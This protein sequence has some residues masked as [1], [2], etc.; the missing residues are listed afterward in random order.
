M[1]QSKLKGI[2]LGTR[3]IALSVMIVVAVMTIGSLIFLQWEKRSRFD[4]LKNTA[5]TVSF[6]MCNL[7]VDPFIYN[8]IMK[9]DGIAANAIKEK[10]VVFAFFVDADGKPLTSVQSGINVNDPLIKSSV[11]EGDDP[12]KVLSSLK[13]NRGVVSMTSPVTDGEK[14]LGN[15]VIG[16]S[17]ADA[18]AAFY[19]AL[20]YMLLM[21]AGIIL[22]LSA[23]MFVMF[24]ET[25][26]KPIR[27]ILDLTDAVAGGDLT[28]T[29][30][31]TSSDEMGHLAAAINKM[32]EGFRDSLRQTVNSAYAVSVAAEKVS[33]NSNVIA[34]S[35]Q[36]ESSAAEQTAASIGKIAYSI[37]QVAKNAGTLAANVDESSSTINEM[38]AS[39]EQVGKS[40]DMMAS[41]VEKASSAVEQMLFSVDQTARNSGAMTEAVSETSMTVE[42]QL[43]SIEKIGRNTESLKRMVIET[44][45]TIEEMIRT[46]KEVAGRIGG[47]DKLSKDAFD[48]AEEGGKAIYRSMESLQNIGKTTE[49]TVGIIRNLGK[50]S[51]EIGSIV[52]VID[53][54]ADQTNLLALNAAIEAARAGEAGRGFA[55]VAEEIRKLAERSIEATKE[56]AGV[57]KQV[58]ADTEVA[59]RAT[60]ETYR[61]GKDGITLAENSRDAFTGIV[62]SMK[63]SSQVIGGV[64]RSAAELN[65]AMG[66]VMKYVLD[67]NASTEEVAGAVKEQVSGADSIRGLLQKMN[68][69]VAEVNIAAKEQ[70]AGG[71]QIRGAVEH[72]KNIV[73]EVGI[74]VKEQVS[75]TQQ[76]V[77]AIETMRKM[78]EDVAGETTE[79]KTGGETI[80]R[81]AEGMSQVS[82]ENL[83]IS[84]DMVN[85]ANDTL[86]QVE[87]LQ[88]SVSSFRIHLNGN[89]RCWDILNCPVS[90]KE[91]CPA[92]NGEE[93]RCWLV[94]GTWCKGTQQ[95]DSRSKLRSCM[96]CEAFKVMQGVEL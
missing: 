17:T 87:N 77:Q 86:F 1:K 44:S 28:R 23:A 76:I 50:R 43:S 25:T 45:G 42:N 56:I 91:K 32:I 63:E 85:I 95:G 58:Q 72:V 31:V 8:D 35:S 79:Q 51:E 69:L 12:A 19:L 82:A 62:T 37:S 66:Q 33:A 46:V 80:V 65:S 34:K 53:E 92:Y 52:E 48:E 7:A 55:V 59:I 16:M 49:T 89:K 11:R 78:T 24:R 84:E 36:E 57:I 96:T 26:V 22:V 94:S 54:I 67:M 21:G 20:K 64:A 29:L 40:A 3:F 70:S 10:S 9:L 2:S 71:R 83:R 73:H 27:N 74:A 93:D 38:A 14:T 88:Y 6:F 4:D 18:Y 90:S 13:T 68:K 5:K 15:L 81:A 47:A 41:S 30:P 39:I 75:G 60:E 61:E